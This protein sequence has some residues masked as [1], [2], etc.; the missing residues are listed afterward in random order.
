ME[1]GLARL[2]RPLTLSISLEPIDCEIL[3]VS[4]YICYVLLNVRDKNLLYGIVTV[5]LISL[6]R[7]EDLTVVG[8]GVSM[9]SLSHLLRSHGKKYVNLCQHTQLLC[10]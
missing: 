10:T 9:S 3:I 4:L 7:L 8:P 5:V 6:C 1:R 2:T